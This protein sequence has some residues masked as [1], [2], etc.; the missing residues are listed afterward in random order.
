MWEPEL[1]QRLLAVVDLR[2]PRGKRD[3]AILL[4]A[5][6]LGLRLGDIKGLTLDQLHWTTTTIEIVQNK[7]GEPLVLPLIEEVWIAC[8]QSRLG[9]AMACS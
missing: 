1:V 8:G 5:A 2:S 6:R 3:Y 9:R 7:T 4:L